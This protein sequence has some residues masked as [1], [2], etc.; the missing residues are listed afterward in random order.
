MNL[1]KIEDSLEKLPESIQLL[2]M[3]LVYPVISVLVLSMLAGV[4][5]LIESIVK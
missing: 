1:E 5:I 3:V 2:I 4:L